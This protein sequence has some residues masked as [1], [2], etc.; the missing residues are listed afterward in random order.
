MI[1]LCCSWVVETFF[2]DSDLSKALG[3]GRKREQV[4]NGANVIDVEASSDLN[5]RLP[6]GDSAKRR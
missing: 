5:R 2:A 3:L 6:E 1:P 4:I